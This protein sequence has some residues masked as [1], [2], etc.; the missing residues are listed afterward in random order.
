[1]FVSFVCFNMLCMSFFCDGGVGSGWPHRSHRKKLQKTTLTTKNASQQKDYRPGVK[2][3]ACGRSASKGQA[4]SLVFLFHC[5]PSEKRSVKKNRCNLKKKGKHP[6]SM[7]RNRFFSGL[8]PATK[9]G[10]SFLFRPSG[11]YFWHFQPQ[12]LFLPVSSF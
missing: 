12:R 10:L 3:P 5:A 1:M 6:D 7:T 9:T 11:S 4:T 2:G 8:T